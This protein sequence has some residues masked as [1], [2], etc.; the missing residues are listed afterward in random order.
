MELFFFG[1]KYL[2]ETD[3]VEVQKNNLPNNKEGQ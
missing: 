3:A 1:R 2:T